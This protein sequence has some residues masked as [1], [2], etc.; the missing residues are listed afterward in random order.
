MKPYYG[1]SHAWADITLDD[2]RSVAFELGREKAET[3]KHRAKVPSKDRKLTNAWLAVERALEAH[4]RTLSSFAKLLGDLSDPSVE[5]AVLNKR[6]IDA[7]EAKVEELS[8]DV[9]HLRSVVD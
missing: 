8:G 7:L 9:A 4:Q 5:H 1:S 3:V 6:K 2:L